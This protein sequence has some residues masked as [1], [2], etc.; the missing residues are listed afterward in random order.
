RGLA[1]A[2]GMEAGWRCCCGGSCGSNM[3]RMRTVHEDVFTVFDRL[4]FRLG[5][6]FCRPMSSLPPLPSS[7]ARRPRKGLARFDTLR[8]KLFLAIAGANVVLVMAAY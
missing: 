1:C 5:P 6:D 4:G 2:H 3:E 8:V 7:P